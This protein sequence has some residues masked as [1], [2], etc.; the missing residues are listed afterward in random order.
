MRNRRAARLIRALRALPF[1][2]WMLP[3]LIGDGDEEAHSGV[4]LG[5]TKRIEA[6]RALQKHGPFDTRGRC[7][8][9]ALEQARPVLPRHRGRVDPDERTA[10]ASASEVALGPGAS[11]DK[12]GGLGGVLVPVAVGPEGAGDGA[13]GALT[14]DSLHFFGFVGRAF[15]GGFGVTSAR[16]AERA[17]KTP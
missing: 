3:G 16:D 10:S 4:V 11:G 8:E 14:G 13:G 7:E 15:A 17:A 6:E 9:R 5:T 12:A 1:A 2:V